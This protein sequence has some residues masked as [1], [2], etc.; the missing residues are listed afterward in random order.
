MVGLL[1]LLREEMVQVNKETAMGLNK[2]ILSRGLSKSVEKDKPR[3]EKELRRKNLK[4]AVA[5][6]TNKLN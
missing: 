1:A 5:A 4:E 2:I 3:V 6:E